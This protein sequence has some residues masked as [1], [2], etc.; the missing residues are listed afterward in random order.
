MSKVTLPESGP[1]KL[2]GFRALWLGNLINQI[3]TWAYQIA[4]ITYAISFGASA[5]SLGLLA[6]AALMPIGMLAP[7]AGAV[8]DTVGPVKPILTASILGVSGSVATLVVIAA[9]GRLLALSLCAFI[10]GLA[11]ALDQPAR[12]RLTFEVV[13]PERLKASAALNGLL[14]NLGRFA[15]PAIGGIAIW[16][17][18]IN[19][20]IIVNAITYIAP[21]LS[22]LIAIKC[23]QITL[24]L[25]I[26]ERG[27]VRHGLIYVARHATLRPLLGGFAVM[28]LLTLNHLALLPLLAK[29]FDSDSGLDLPIL[30]ASLGV[31]AAIGN[32]A[33]LR[34]LTTEGATH[35]AGAIIVAANTALYFLA[36]RSVWAAATLLALVGFGLGIYMPLLLARIQA[37]ADPAVQGRVAAIFVALNF[38]TDAPA[39]LLVT[40]IVAMAAIDVGFAVAAVGASAAFIGLL[41]AGRVE[42]RPDAPIAATE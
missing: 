24:P 26:R 36:T 33:V 23:R 2:T 17:G 4:A 13:G 41:I 21:A 28:S 25:S 37:D 31:G 16:L 18:S 29:T 12:L 20:A 22:A 5:S 32:L 40:A 10:I 38:G 19:A 14:F 35:M 8:A 15:G 11:L 42:A 39:A 9:G 27:A 3:G 1:W 6:A 34:A 30:M 7:A